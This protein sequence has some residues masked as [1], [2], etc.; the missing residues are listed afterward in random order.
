MDVGFTTDKISEAKNEVFKSSTLSKDDEHVWVS[1][2]LRL[3]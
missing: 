2:W 3:R 1:L